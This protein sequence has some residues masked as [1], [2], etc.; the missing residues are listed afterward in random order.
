MIESFVLTRVLGWKLHGQVPDIPQSVIIVA[1]HTSYWDAVIGKL[2]LRSVGLKHKLLSKKEL[3]FFP[4][5]ILMQLF[6]AIPIRGVK[7]RNAILE[8]S[9]MFESNDHL[10]VVIC[11][12][13]GFTRTEKWNAG[14][15]YIALKA[16]VPIVVAYM[17]YYKKEIG[18]KG[19]IMDLSNIDSVYHELSLYYEGVSARYPENFALPKPRKT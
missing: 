7:G 6:G 5:N 10:H 14:F 13:G 12:E 9:S 4:A 17:D 19:I 3:F 11:P 8:V 18:V 15:Y 2:F 1:P 16:G